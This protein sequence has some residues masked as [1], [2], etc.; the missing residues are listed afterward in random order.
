MFING[1]GNWTRH[2]KG[3]KQKK[4]TMNPVH[5]TLKR[6]GKA[7]GA[8]NH[9]RAQIIKKNLRIGHIKEECVK[10]YR[11]Q[12]IRRIFVANA[13]G[14]RKR[15]RELCYSKERVCGNCAFFG[16]PLLY[17]PCYSCFRRQNMK[18]TDNWKPKS[19]FKK[20]RRA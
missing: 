3:I 18:T 10:I 4:N 8:L 15:Y 7:L 13:W 14:Q 19:F 20:R 5:K 12:T 11:N 16:E 9:K 17:E 6:Y 2:G 1:R